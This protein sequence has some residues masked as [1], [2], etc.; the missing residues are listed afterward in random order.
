MYARD[1]PRPEAAGRPLPAVRPA[2]YAQE[3][4]YFLDELASGNAVYNILMVWRLTGP[5]RV[6]ALRGALDLVVSR[7]EAL[8]TTIHR[9]DDGIRQQVAPHRPLTL[10][11]TDLSG[12]SEADRDKRLNAEIAAL[13]ARPYDL[14]TGP[15]HRFALFRLGTREHVLC[16][17][18][19]HI[20]TD[21]W[22]TG[23]INAEIS[24]AYRDLC[25]GRTPAL[26]EITL[27]YTDFAV[28]Q[29]ERRDGAGL[30][31]DLDFWRA[32][33]DGVR[34]LDLP[35]DRPGSS[36]GGGRGS[37]LHR[38]LSA[39]VR[40]LVVR[41]GADGASPFMVLAAALNVVLS[42]CTG[43]HDIPLGVPM[44]GRPEPQLESVVGMFVNMVVLRCDLSGDPTFRDV[45]DRVMEGTFELYDHQEA[46]FNR[47]VDAVRPVREPGRNP[48]FQ[49]SLQVLAGNTAGANLSLPGVR[50]RLL[51]QAAEGSRFD[52]AITLV[53][54]GTA[55]SAA[56]EYS[57]DRFDAWR[58]EA[59]LTHL[60]TVLRAAAAA[61][62][63]PVARIE[64]VAGDELR[65]LL[66]SGHGAGTGGGSGTV[67]AAVARIARTR[68]AAT[69]FIGGDHELTYAGLD[70]RAAALAARLRAAGLEAGGHVVVVSDRWDHVGVAALGVWR[71]GGVL[72]HLS[73]QEAVE[74]LDPV[75]ADTGALLVLTDNGS[76][77]GLPDSSAWSPVPIRTAGEQEPSTDSAGPVETAVAER[78]PAQVVYSA[79]ATGGLRGV[80]LPHSALSFSADGHRSVLRLGGDDRLFLPPIAAEVRHGALWAALTCGAAVITAEPEKAGDAAHLSDLLSGHGVTH[81]HLPPAL[82]ARLDPAA[83]PALVCV[84]G[85]DRELP[86]PDAR[87]WAGGERRFV[88]I[89]E[90]PGVPVAC[91]RTGPGDIVPYEN[92]SLY[93]VDDALNPVPRGVEGRLLV[94]GAPGT[95]ADGPVN[96]SG[97]GAGYFLP[98]PFRPGR[99]ALLTDERARWNHG[100]GL[101][102]LGTARE[103]ISVEGVRV[104]SAHVEALLCGHPDVAAAVVA[105]DGAAGPTA[106]VRAYGDRPPDMAALGAHLGR[107]LPPALIPGRWVSLPD[108]PLR[109]DWEVDRDAVQD[110]GASAGTGAAAGPEPLTPTEEA[111]AAVFRQVLDVGELA[112]EESFF[113]AGGNSLQAMRAISRVNTAF[114]IRLSVRVMYG[115]V[116]VRAIAAL[117]DEK[118]GEVRR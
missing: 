83:L 42:R 27:D 67:P 78:S 116:T 102:L 9:T 106:F 45:L 25:E 68:P 56:V 18:F 36:E 112:A 8:R 29:R 99:A 40:D 44:L 113:S 6:E 111:V 35:A 50:A 3:Q 66:E 90:L 26:G 1:E 100:A 23:L 15:L 49:V 30:K 92:R 86:T 13:N 88:T 10:P 75:A 74:R 82:R 37:T 53:D 46:P 43:R 71:A 101:E 2:S 114:G 41:L 89:G 59:L 79:D 118:L 28:A 80:R 85:S 96:G 108:L 76:R 69:A 98:D 62:D 60:E 63:Q 110:A 52:V 5:L 32:R 4:L 58:P 39:D 48:L 105:Q 93:V 70:R 73:V 103:G 97:A 51:P 109:A 22:S 14:G 91:V 95:M 72:T 117:V 38:R 81:A 61:P 20:V 104:P 24:T 84:R 57:T 54:D 107:R 77:G 31:E 33:L 65:L 16:Q 17:G 7:H 47:V 11:T 64:L 21:G 19:H 94:G 34:V 115:N 12:L 55:L 87:A